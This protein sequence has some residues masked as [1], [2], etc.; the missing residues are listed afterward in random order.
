[1]SRDGAEDEYER[2]IEA[3][4][5][6]IDDIASGVEEIDGRTDDLVRG[7]ADVKLDIIEVQQRLEGR[8]RR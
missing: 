3:I 4:E 8:T 7:V 5:A 1:M 6:K 2:R